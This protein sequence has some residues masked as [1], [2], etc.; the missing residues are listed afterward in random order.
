MTGAIECINEDFNVGTRMPSA[1]EGINGDISE[2]PSVNEDI[3][4]DTHEM[5][6]VSDGH[7]RGRQQDSVR[8]SAR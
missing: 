4:E 7:Q 8:Q 1:S 3:N 2:I 6:S 5:P